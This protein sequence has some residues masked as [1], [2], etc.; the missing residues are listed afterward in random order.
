M[1]KKITTPDGDTYEGE[2]HQNGYLKS[3]KV[4][5]HGGTSLEGEFYESGGLN[6]GKISGG[7]DG[8]VEEGKFH[9][10]SV[11]ERSDGNLWQGKITYPDGSFDE[12]EFNEFG[13]MTRKYYDVH[14]FPEPSSEVPDHDEHCRCEY[15]MDY[16]D[17]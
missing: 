12:G 14:E 4:T 16:L 1:R 11:H 10:G 5:L 8:S 6:I 15:C 7:R 2:F 3:G 17:Q 13:E 9:E